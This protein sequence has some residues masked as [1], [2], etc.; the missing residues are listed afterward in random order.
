VPFGRLENVNGVD[1]AWYG[2]AFVGER[3][4]GDGALVVSNG[5]QVF[6]AMIDGMGHGPAAYKVAAR[7]CEYLRENW[8]PDLDSTMA[9]VDKELRETLGGSVGMC[10]L[11]LSSGVIEYTAVGNI[12][13]RLEGSKC[14][15]FYAKEGVVGIRQMSLRHHRAMMREG[16]VLVMHTD[17]I[18]ERFRMEDIPQVL[19]YAA[20]RMARA[21][22]EQFGKSHDD[23]TCLVLKRSK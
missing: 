20:G 15:K 7:A 4:S 18:S 1:C 21:I 22:V 23:V 3:V 19:G 17:G 5:D 14:Q 9:A 2:R 12:I 16:D 13:M 11:D 6:L 8:S 10:T